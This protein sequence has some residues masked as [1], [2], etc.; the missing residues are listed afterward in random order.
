MGTGRGIYLYIP[1][2]LPLLK[3]GRLGQVF[4]IGASL[5]RD[6]NGNTGAREPTRGVGGVIIPHPR[7]GEGKGGD[8]FGY[9]AMLPVYPNIPSWDKERLQTELTIYLSIYL[10]VPLIL[11]CCPVVSSVLVEE[12]GTGQ[13]GVGTGGLGDTLSTRGVGRGRVV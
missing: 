13:D 2:P 8:I 9:T 11:P 5:F 10:F 4:P 3:E 7:G 6:S 12:T 1:P